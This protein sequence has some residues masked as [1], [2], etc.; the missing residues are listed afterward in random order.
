MI[1]SRLTTAASRSRFSD[2][3]AAG[4]TPAELTPEHRRLRAILMQALPP[5]GANHE[6]SV[7]SYDT[8]TGIRLYAALQA[9]GFNVR[10]AADDGVWRHLSLCVLPDL[11]E[12]RWPHKPEERFWRSRS[13]IW[14]RSIWW[15][16]HLAWQGSEAATR[17]ALSGVTTDMVVQLIERPG[18]N[19]FRVDLARTLFS[20]RSV[21]AVGQNDF[22]AMMK[23]NTARLMV[24]APEFA[25]GGISGY[26]RRLRL[27]IVSSAGGRSRHVIRK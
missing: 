20:E 12:Q 3:K 24:V 16:T 10:A 1:W 22:R 23:L 2:M 6:E 9:E 8:S 11:V 21:H 7:G 5:C 14:L 26:V 25:E 4:F 19:G 27:A 18:R 13:R 17:T 15:L